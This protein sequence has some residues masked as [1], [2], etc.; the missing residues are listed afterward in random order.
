[1]G[2]GG[3]NSITTN[4]NTMASPFGGIP[5]DSMMTSTVGASQGSIPTPSNYDNLRG[6]GDGITTNSNT[7]ASTSNAIPANKMAASTMGASQ[8]GIPIPSNPNHDNMNTMASPF[9]DLP[10]DS[11]VTSTMG[12]SQGGI[13]TLSNYDNMQDIGDGITTNNNTVA[14]TN[15]GIPANRMIASIM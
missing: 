7:M 12:A 14:S 5:V 10:R 6:I 2:Q 13:P 8:G 11:M 15:D 9:G 3:G 4:N 1:M